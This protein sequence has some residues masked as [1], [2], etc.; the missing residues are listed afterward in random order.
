RI[1]GRPATPEVVR[2]VRSRAE[3]GQ[4][5]SLVVER[6]GAPVS[7]EV[8]VA[9]S[10]RSYRGYLWYRIGLAVVSWFLG[11]ALIVRRGRTT[12]SLVLGV[13]LLAY[14][15]ITLPS[16]SA[17]SDVVRSLLRH[18]WHLLGAAH[19]F[20]FP[21]LLFHFIALQWPVGSRLRSRRLWLGVYGVVAAVLLVTTVGLTDPL[22]WTNPGPHRAVRGV[23]GLGFELH[24]FGAA[25]ALMWRRPRIA[26]Q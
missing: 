18:G 15:P 22:A 11:L 8:P 9:A 23:A 4:V 17:A 14:L 10:T 7:L 25:V 16:G 24:A 21:A 20:L 26:P 12:A 5:L 3:P 2:E 19:R 1:E 6:R 13:A